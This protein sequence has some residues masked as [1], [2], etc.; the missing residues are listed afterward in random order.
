MS[1]LLDANMPV[2]NM[3]V[4]IIGAGPAGL[5]CA[6]RLGE[7]GIA[8]VVLD[9]EPQPGGLPAQCEHAGFG[10][11]TYKRLMRGREFAARLLQRAERANVNIHTNTTVLEVTDAREALAVSPNGLQRYRARAL[12]LATG[13]RELPRSTL[14]V[15]GTRPAGIFNTG[16][17]QRLHTFLHSAPGRQAVIV[18]SDD[19]SLMAAPS[20]IQ[21]G[22]R[23][24]A[25]LEERPYRQGYLGLEWLTLR[26]RR[27]PLLLHHKILEIRGG[28]RV[29]EI[30]VA[31]L[32][33]NGA[34]RG[35][36]FVIP[37]DTLIFSGEFVPENVLARQLNLALDAHT[38][39]PRVDQNFET[40]VRGIF[41]CGNLVHAADAADHALADGEQTARG[42]FD[43]LQREHAEPQ[44]VQQ[45]LAGDG[46]RAV[47]PQCLRWYDAQCA[48]VH[49]AVRVSHA[50]WGV[51]VRAD[52]AER[53]FGRAYTFAAK[54]HR[55]IY[56]K[57]SPNVS[58][59][60][61]LRVSAHG[62]V[63]SD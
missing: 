49:L 37:C 23:V 18:G 38:R 31:R 60:E 28:A 34:P 59:D 10:L 42:V 19:M 20:L 36:P 63:T 4:L 44:S 30:L 58:S 55:S 51:R 14:A 61:P 47:V 62:R 6:A 33:A 46:V 17:V 22:V 26:P 57:I 35:E 50:L 1:N 12:V 7:R 48:P 8:S 45:I 24:R 25:V 29:Q 3:D 15:A 27:I 11:F 32:D 39:G 56:L 41:A 21:L 43:F 16:V 40:D 9:R 2:Q 5:A 53:N 13:C 54:P 52:T